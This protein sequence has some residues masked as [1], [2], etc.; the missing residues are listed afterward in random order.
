MPVF[1]DKERTDPSPKR[2]NE[3]TYAFYDRVAGEKF[4]VIRDLVNTWTGELPAS[5][6]SEVVARFRTPEEIKFD[7]AVAEIVMHAAFRRLG[8]QVDV[9]P[10]LGDVRRTPDF[11]LRDS[12]DKPL[13]YVEVTSIN[14][15][16][17]EVGRNNREA[18]IFEALNQVDIP[19]DLGLMYDV[20]AFGQDS[21]STQWARRE[22]ASW[23]IENAERARRQEN[24]ERV[25]TF[26]T[27]RLRLSLHALSEDRPNSRKVFMWGDINGRFTG[28]LEGL[29]AL[30]RVLDTKVGRYGALNLPFLIVVFDRINRFG[31]L[32]EDL[33]D[34]VAEALFGREFRAERVVSG[35]TVKSTLTRETSGWMG[36]PGAPRNTQA[37]AVMVFP[38]CDI[39]RLGDPLRD[40]LLVHHPWAAQ[41]LPVDML[42]FR[43]LEMDEKAGRVIPGTSIGEILGLPQPWPPEN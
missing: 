39:W 14:P 23:A 4:E 17:D 28:P 13:A 41:P 24:V 7:T 22:V 9:H 21:F 34:D 30:G 6:I 33:P 26:R 11:L 37:S 36:H 40:P 29:D 8:F 15:P 16:D 18:L 10:D 42:P 19:G 25:F 12:T 27:W 5:E 31:F 32:A 35:R 2:R 20:E 1:E 38:H 43:R 3:L